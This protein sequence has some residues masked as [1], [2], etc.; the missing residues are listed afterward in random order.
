MNFVIFDFE[1]F[2]YDTLLG[3]IVIDENDNKQT[4]QMWNEDDIRSFYALHIDDVW[5]GHNNKCYDNLILQAYQ[6]KKS[7]CIRDL[8]GSHQF[9]TWDQLPLDPIYQF[10][11]AKNSIDPQNRAAIDV[12]H[13]FKNALSSSKLN[14]SV[15][16][17]YVN[18]YTP[19]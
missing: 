5:I 9:K 6:S 19:L 11:K 15:E 2:R 4:I 1:V 12:G 17:D 7:F 3:C 8:V 13:L 16:K 18:R 10:H 14:F